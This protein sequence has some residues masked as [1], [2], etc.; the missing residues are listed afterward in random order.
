MLL[1]AR[2]DTTR[3]KQIYKDY[4]KPDGEACRDDGTLKDASKLEWPNSP[5]DINTGPFNLDPGELEESDENAFL[6]RKSPGD[7]DESD[8]ENV[9]LPKIKVCNSLVF[10]KL[11]T[12]KLEQ[13]KLATILD[14]DEDE[15]D[16]LGSRSKVQRKVSVG[17]V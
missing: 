2:S 8:Y 3:G 15:V 11:A 16:I 6:K 14:S 4:S 9:D 17:T 12:D 10:W 7:E 13:R 5:S 1:D